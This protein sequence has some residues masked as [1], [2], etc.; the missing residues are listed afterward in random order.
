MAGGST[1]DLRER[2]AR[3]EALLGVPVEE[4]SSTTIMEQLAAA[5]KSISDLQSSLD[6]HSARA[7]QRL[8]ERAEEQA[9][10]AAHRFEGMGEEI[11]SMQDDI[12]GFSARFD[13]E[14]DIL[15]RAIRGLPTGGEAT[16]K[17]KV[18]EPKPF[19]GARSAKELE[20]FLWDMEQYFRAAR[21][22][23][24]ERVTITTMYLD[25]DAKLWWRTREDDDSGRPKITNWEALRK[26]L[27]DQFLPCNTAWVARDSL[28]KLKHTTSVREYVKQF[29]SLMLDIKDMSEADKLYN[30]TSGLQVW[31]QLE[32]R[33]QGVRDLPSAMA[34]ADALVDFRQS[35]ED[36]EKPKPKSKDKGKKKVGNEKP[37]FKGKTDKGKGRVVDK[38]QPN[39]NNL[40]CFICNGPHRARDCPKKEKLNALV[41]EEGPEA[42]GGEFQARMNP[43]QMRLN[44]LKAEPSTVLMY[45][46]VEANSSKS[47]AMLDTG[48][49]HN[50]VAARMITRLGLKLSKCP[51]KLKAVN[52]EAQPVVGIAHAVSLKVGEWTGEVNFLVVP[53]DDFDI[54]LGNEFF[55]LA[56]AAPM[57]FLRGMLIMDKAHPCYVKAIKEAPPPHGSSKDGALSAMQLKHGLRR[58]D[59]TYLAALREVKEESC[60]D[61][62]EQ[63]LSLLEEFEDVMPPELPKTLPPRRNVDH[64]IELL[65]GSTPPARAPYRMSPKELAELQRQLT[66]LLETGFIQP[67]KAPYGAPVLFQKKKDGSLRMCVDYRAL[68]K[69]TVKNK[70]PVPL[71]QDL[72]DRLSRASYYT[73]LDLRSGYWQVRIAEGDE[74]KTTCVTRY[75]SFEFLVMPFGLTNAPATFCNLMNDVFY[76]YIDKFVVVYL[77]DIVV[78]S[79][80]FV[81][82]LSHL[83][84]VLTR[85]RENSLYVKKEKCEFARRE[86]LFLGH[87]ISAGKILMDEGKV[88]AIQDWSPPKTVSGLRSFLG[89]ANYYRKFIAAYS[90]KAA[91]LTDLLKKDRQ[92]RWTDQ[93]QAA[94]DKLKAAVASEPVL[95]LPD[96]ELPFEVHTDASDRAIGGVLVQEGHPVAYESRKLKE[97]EQRYSAH[98]KEMLAVVHC[99]LVW[100][101]YLLGTKFVVRTDNA[102]NTF[103]QTQKKLS[104]KQARWQE[105]LQEYDFVWVHKP[106]KHNQVADAL[107]RK[108]HDP[109]GRLLLEVTLLHHAVGCSQ[110]AAHSSKALPPGGYK[111]AVGALIRGSWKLHCEGVL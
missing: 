83:R 41:T 1:Q 46:P 35:K 107:S 43:L 95:H 53:L 24:T 38:P 85:L 37:K 71:I 61:A 10:L 12:K 74:P 69:V 11:E 66:E 65:P 59:V 68:N 92:W 47:T 78:Y 21:I 13:A 106:G 105:F 101:V 25:G 4:S 31:A 62:P 82:H 60:V 27:R 64:R 56:E 3:L 108:E 23:E 81:N 51:S 30:F 58:G 89:L 88:K 14:L 70:Y 29:S 96:F 52:S 45:V 110:V 44:A 19:G 8:E 109:G 55:V 91:P 84:L 33:R 90:K 22:P 75:G 15:K 48:A 36:G 80:S 94:F 63:V 73:K 103:F 2:V 98:E 57:P 93:C 20:N 86:I 6:A 7:L 79:E 16:A 5:Q 18:P 50:F 42:G 97:A 39:K 72:F 67:S 17:L 40:G 111:R 77:D 49:T 104:A 28:K 26:E 32:L 100:R 76:D 9:D 99:L 102:A 34:A 54:I 87:K